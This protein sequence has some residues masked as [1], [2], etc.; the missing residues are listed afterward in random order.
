[1]FSGH[2]FELFQPYLIFFDLYNLFRP[3]LIF[4]DLFR[5]FLTISDFF[6]SFPT[7]FDHFRPFSNFSRNFFGQIT[8]SSLARKVAQSQKFIF[9]QL[10]NLCQDTFCRNRFKPV[11]KVHF[12]IQKRHSSWWSKTQS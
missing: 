4:S 10:T 7:F 6:R 3:F 11:G 8:R 1:M 2:I 5:P 12:K 9:L